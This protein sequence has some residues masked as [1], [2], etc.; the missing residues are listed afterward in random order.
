MND[1]G[2]KGESNYPTP[3]KTDETSYPK[4]CL[5][6]K[7]M[8]EFLGGQKVELGDEFEVK[9]K[10]RVSGMRKDKHSQSLD[11]EVLESEELDLEEKSESEDEDAD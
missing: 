1:L 3:A 7:A 11:L 6:D 8:D 2:T 10:V 9:L 5:Y 4:L